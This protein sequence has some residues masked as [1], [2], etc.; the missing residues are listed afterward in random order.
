MGLKLVVAGVGKK[1]FKSEHFPAVDA[2]PVLMSLFGVLVL[3]ECPEEICEFDS[4]SLW[5]ASTFSFLGRGGNIGGIRGCFL[6]LAHQH[7]RWCPPLLLSQLYHPVNPS[8]YHVQILMHHTPSKN[9]EVSLGL[10]LG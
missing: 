1:D 4:S 6:G 3:D 7:N 9:P 10:L 5:L 2:E 8:L